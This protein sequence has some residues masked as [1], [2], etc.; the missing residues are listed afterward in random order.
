MVLENLTSLGQA[1]LQSG[2]NN[3]YFSLNTGSMSSI[4]NELLRANA[5]IP[6]TITIHQGSIA[7][8]WI[9]SPIDFSSCYRLASTE[10]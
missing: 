3:S 6:P 5:N 4:A 7:G 8:V 2:N 9:D 1:A 10:R